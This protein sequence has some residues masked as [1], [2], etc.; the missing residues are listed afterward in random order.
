M[1]DLQT[2]TVLGPLDIHTVPVFRV[3]RPTACTH[4]FSGGV[5]SEC[6]AEKGSKD[7]DRLRIAAEQIQ[8]EG[9]Q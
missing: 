3:H 4:L 5:C 9:L 7:A 2:F 1:S 6:G 8:P